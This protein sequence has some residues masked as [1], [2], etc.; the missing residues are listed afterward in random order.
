M[1][2]ILHII[3]FYVPANAKLGLEYAKHLV[4][5]K[6][7]RSITGGCSSVSSNSANGYH[8]QATGIPRFLYIDPSGCML[9]VEFLKNLG[10]HIVESLLVNCYRTA[11]GDDPVIGV[12]SP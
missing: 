2:H 8:T 7:A 3:L 5:L 9:V 1:P 6:G 11:G 10:L 12:Y 4:H